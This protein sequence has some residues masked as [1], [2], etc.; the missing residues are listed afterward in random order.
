LSHL[1]GKLA[2]MTGACRESVLCQLAF[3]LACGISIQMWER[4]KLSG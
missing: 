3:A 2:L 4:G 1:L